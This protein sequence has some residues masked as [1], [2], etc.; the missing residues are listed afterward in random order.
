MPHRFHIPQGSETGS[1]DSRRRSV[2]R[3]AIL[4]MEFGGPVAQ[5]PIPCSSMWKMAGEQG[6]GEE[7]GGGEGSGG[8]RREQQLVGSSNHQGNTHLIDM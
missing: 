2:A 8:K 7:R 6:G 4:D 3:G 5:S 1:G